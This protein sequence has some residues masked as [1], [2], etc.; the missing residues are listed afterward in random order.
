M[1]INEFGKQ[2]VMICK[3]YRLKADGGKKILV[4]L[5]SLLLGIMARL[6][7]LIMERKIFN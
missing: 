4:F 1:K 7:T 2:T 5:F 3:P 6:R